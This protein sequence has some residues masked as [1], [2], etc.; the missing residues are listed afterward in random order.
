VQGY[1]VPGR[2]PSSQAPWE[3]FLGNAAHRLITY[4]Y[5]VNHPR[6]QASYNTKTIASIVEKEGLGDPSQLLPHERNLCPDITDL[7][8][9][10]VFEIKPW[11]H[12]GLL[13]GRQELQ[14]YLTALNRAVAPEM[15]FVGGLGFQGQI[16][17]RFAQGQYIWRLEWQT[18]EPGITQ[19]RWT[20]SQQRFESERAAYE[21]G[22]WVD[23]TVEEMRQYGGWVGQAVEG[24][25][26]RRE[27]LATARGAVGILITIIGETARGVFTGAILG[28]M[29][30]GSGAQ[31][32]PTQGGGRVIP[33]PSR[34]PA[35]AQPVQLPAAANGQ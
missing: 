31:Q 32:P 3:F 2:N 13:E 34:P 4:M 26:T 1:N 16:L 12:Q 20:R 35:S 19:Y 27:Q 14:V 23:L 8:A 33:F 10:H 5:S 15:L 22:Q 18:A 7:T 17:V 28:R 25:V 11:N 30:P 6:N 29:L 24:M 9:L 21:A